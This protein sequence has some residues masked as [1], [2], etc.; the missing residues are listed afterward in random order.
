MCPGLLSRVSGGGAVGAQVNVSKVSASLRTPRALLGVS[1][2]CQ[3]SSAFATHLSTSPLTNA[4]CNKTS[5]PRHTGCASSQAAFQACAGSP[6]ST[7]AAHESHET[8]RKVVFLLDT[9][10]WEPN[11][12]R[13]LVINFYSWKRTLIFTWHSLCILKARKLMLRSMTYKRSS[14]HLRA[15]CVQNL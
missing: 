2:R 10:L 5:R 8:G 1:S 13:C 7:L 14:S 4:S 9:C 3:Q 12:L 15:S 6:P 11:V